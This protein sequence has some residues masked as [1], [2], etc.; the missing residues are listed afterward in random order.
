MD[1]KRIKKQQVLVWQ[2]ELKKPPDRALESASIRMRETCDDP[3]GFCD[4]LLSEACH[5]PHLET[6]IPN[7]LL[8]LEFCRSANSP[9]SQPLFLKNPVHDLHMTSQLDQL[10]SNSNSSSTGTSDKSSKSKH[11]SNDNNK[12][13]LLLVQQKLRPQQLGGIMEPN[14]RNMNTSPWIYG[15]EQ[16]RTVAFTAAGIPE[17]F[18]PLTTR[19]VFH[20]FTPPNPDAPPAL[21]ASDPSP[22]ATAA[23]AAAAA[24][25]KE[26]ERLAKKEQDKPAAVI[27]LSSPKSPSKTDANRKD[28]SES[29]TKKAESSSATTSHSV[30]FASPLATVKQV[31]PI[32]HTTPT[33]SPN[34]TIKPETAADKSSTPTTTSDG[35]VVMK[36]APATTDSTEKKDDDKLSETDKTKTSPPPPSTTDKTEE[37]S[38]DGAKDGTGNYAMEVDGETKKKDEEA[39]KATDTTKEATS[40]PTVEQPGEGAKTVSASEEKDVNKEGAALESDKDKKEE[41]PSAPSASA[42]TTTTDSPAKPP[43]A[44]DSASNDSK[45]GSNAKTAEDVPP[46]TTVEDKK[47]EVASDVEMKDASSSDM[48]TTATTKIEGTTSGIKQEEGAKIEG[49][50][51]A[52]QKSEVSSLQTT[53]PQDAA[54]TAGETDKAVT[55]SNDNKDSKSDSAGIVNEKTDSEATKKD[56]GAPETS[57]AKNISPVK[58]EGDAPTKTED[59]PESAAT[60]KKS[61]P[62][63]PVK[64]E[65][66]KKDAQPDPTK[67]NSQG[68]TTSKDAK[69]VEAKVTPPDTPS[70]TAVSKEKLTSVPS[71]STASPTKPTPAPSSIPPKAAATTS[72]S[73]I[74]PVSTVPTYHL[75]DNRYLEINRQ[76]E[77]ISTVRLL[78]SKRLGNTK[79]NSKKKRKLEQL[80]G[81]AQSALQNL[82]GSLQYMN[83][84]ALT[85]VDAQG[86]E[87]WIKQRNT[88]DRQVEKWLETFRSS[89]RAYWKEEAMLKKPKKTYESTCFSEWHTAD[90]L[91]RTC[92]HCSG[93]KNKGMHSYLIGDEIMQ[94]L[95]CS[96]VGCGP[97]SVAPNSQHQH[98]LQH[99]FLSGHKFGKTRCA[100]ICF[101]GIFSCSSPLK[102]WS[103][104]SFVQPSRVGRKQRYS[105]S[106]VAISFTIVFS[107]KSES[108]WI[109]KQKY[110]GLA[111]RTI[112]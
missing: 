45:T 27:S 92:L 1:S 47:E 84:R 5:C 81:S 96:F 18:F 57:S 76:E 53:K 21:H 30:S 89:R 67:S 100:F 12:D 23:A 88:A 8:D 38:K 9:R 10:T 98:I 112:P 7:G 63:S 4:L 108:G 93:M 34:T 55:S 74:K 16:Q 58:R 104:I 65:E 71:P 22:A 48:E 32:L 103:Y 59:K 85:E 49:E 24:A 20:E 41:K 46:T 13:P 97:V 83:E 68:T 72:S 52:T 64:G 60:E 78:L 109:L 44:K 70:S 106:D 11:S 19:H 15:E 51:D 2:K 95:E 94:C 29:P 39:T 69:P 56:P 26:I 86:R 14:V 73:S 66:Q 6:F 99:L 105:V 3:P 91:R 62:S 25:A 54:S 50:V 107:I 36:D 40:A 31:E 80:S 79:K 77:R 111:G 43:G 87:E 110:H 75:S 101:I 82:P 102:M 90:T 42:G 33:P 61:G 35:D 37:A 17:R 28:K